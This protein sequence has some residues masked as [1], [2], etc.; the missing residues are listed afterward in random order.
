M[1]PFRWELI[2]AFHYLP[3]FAEL[4]GALEPLPPAALREAVM[5]RSTPPTGIRRCSSTRS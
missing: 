3:H 4:R 5:V 2:D 1:L